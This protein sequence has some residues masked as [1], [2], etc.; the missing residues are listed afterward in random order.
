MSGQI[1]TFPNSVEEFME[2]YKMVDTEHIYSNGTEYVPIFRMK[3][4]FE[5]LDNANVDKNG[6]MSRYINADAIEYHEVFEGDEFVRVAY[7]DDI[8]ELPTADVVEK[9]KWDRLLENS[10]ILAEA[11]QKYQLADMVEVVRCKDC[12]RQMI[13]FHSDNYFCA[14]GERRNDDKG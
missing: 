9:E 2:S 8:D 4:W 3:Q 13:C 10:I 14:D 7:G 11:V 6:R 1:M 5:H 12:T